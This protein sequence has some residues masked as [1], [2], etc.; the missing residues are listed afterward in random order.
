MDN[1]VAIIGATGQTG[2]HLVQ[3]LVAQNIPVRVLS[4][5]SS[6]AKKMFGN[7]V[8]I[9]EG[10]LLKAKD[11]KA[12]VGGVTHLFAAHGAD[13]YPGERGYELIDYGG[14]DKALESIP[15]EQHTHIIYLSS[16]YP[17]FVF[18]D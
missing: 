2:K 13:N 16:I 3:K 12:L 15:A 14:M 1:L 8:E 7:T 6:K 17:M 10:D 5:N 18:D 9:I 4:R 11:L